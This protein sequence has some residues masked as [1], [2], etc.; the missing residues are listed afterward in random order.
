MQIIVEGTRVWIL[1]WQGYPREIVNSQWYG[2][3]VIET[4]QFPNTKSSRARPAILLCL[5]I[6]DLV[7]KHW[8]VEKYHYWGKVA[9]HL[10]WMILKV[11]WVYENVHVEILLL[12]LF[13]PLPST[14]TSSI[15]LIYALIHD[16]NMQY[17]FVRT[18]QLRL[19]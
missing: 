19:L 2:P 12:E 4:L 10:I 18:S 16:V 1:I 3:P 14:P 7:S 15:N 5:I 13:N 6:L 8:G 11:K 17:V 9:L